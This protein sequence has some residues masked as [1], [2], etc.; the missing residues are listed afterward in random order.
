MHKIL[1]YSCSLF[2]DWTDVEVRK[3]EAS[4]HRGLMRFLL[5]EGMLKWGVISF[6]IFS[7]ATFKSI[8]LEAEEPVTYFLLS[9]LVWVIASLCYGAAV[10]SATNYAFH[11]KA[12]LPIDN[13]NE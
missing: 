4:K 11:R 12:K 10:W 9:C 5:V 1:I 6:I 7:P 13:L 2:K 3:W 8:T